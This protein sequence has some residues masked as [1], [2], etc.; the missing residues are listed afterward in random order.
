MLLLMRHIVYMRRLL[1]REIISILG[2]VV[3]SNLNCRRLALK[4]FAVAY[5][6]LGAEISVLRRILRLE[7]ASLLGAVVK[8]RGWPLGA[9]RALRK[10]GPLGTLDDL[11]WHGGLDHRL[12]RLLR[13]RVRNG[14]ELDVLRILGGKVL[15]RPL[16]T[17]TP[18]HLVRTHLTLIIGFVLAHIPLSVRYSAYQ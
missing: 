1:R 15:G 2:V 11:G 14:D 4:K 17:I 12:R 9:R 5:W 7:T 8:I 10:S 18:S 16:H 13:G 3:A 6:T